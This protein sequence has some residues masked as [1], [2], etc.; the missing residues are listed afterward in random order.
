MLFRSII[1]PIYEFLIYSCVRNGVFVV[2]I[3][4]LALENVDPYYSK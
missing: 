1:F 4:L 2:Q 3:F